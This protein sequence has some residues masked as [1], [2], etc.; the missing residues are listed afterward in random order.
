M[1]LYLAFWFATLL[2]TLP[3]GKLLQALS[4]VIIVLFIGFRYE[5]G[6]DWPFYQDM[7]LNL[8]LDYVLSDWVY[9]YNLYGV[10][11]GF[12]F[13]VGNTAPVIGFEYFQAFV[14]VFFI[15][16]T[17]MLARTVGHKNPAL[18]LAVCLTYLLLTLVFSTIRQCLAI[19]LFNIGVAVYLQS[20]FSRTVRIWTVAVFFALATSIQNSAL[21]YCMAFCYCS[22]NL[23]QTAKRFLVILLVLLMIPAVI[24]PEI[25]SGL[26]ESRAAAKIQFYSEVNSGLF[27]SVN[28]Y[29]LILLA[30]ISLGLLYA[31]PRSQISKLDRLEKLVS[32]ARVLLVINI[33][34]IPFAIARDRISYELFIV[35]SILFTHQFAKLKLIFPTGLITLGVFWSSFG[36]LYQYT[37]IVFIPYQNYLVYSL[38]DIPSDGRRRQE[39]FFEQYDQ[40]L[41]SYR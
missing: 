31:I 12:L 22:I 14:A 24:Y 4:V 29:Y 40:R 38:M 19:S 25:V 13:L 1:L 36:T 10:E 16:S 2:L 17:M 15:Y 30:F 32:F 41:K 11:L 27:N 8:S 9:N 33:L 21:I 18:A 7:Y 34:C 3:G 26:I 35:A 37:G 28:A 39:Q 23:S 20:Y 5:T 6:F